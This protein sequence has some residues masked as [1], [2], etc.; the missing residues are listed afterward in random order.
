M[1][2]V[3]V[4]IIIVK[5]NVTLSSEQQLVLGDALAALEGCNAPVVLSHQEARNPEF[6]RYFQL[7]SR[8]LQEKDLL[9]GAK[10]MD[11]TVEPMRQVMNNAIDSVVRQT[12]IVKTDQ[13]FRFV[14][15]AAAQDPSLNL[16]VIDLEEPYA[17]REAHS[18]L[19][20]GL[21][22]MIQPTLTQSEEAL[23]LKEL[24]HESGLLLIGSGAGASVI[25]GAALGPFNQFNSGSVSL[26]ALSSVAL[27]EMVALCD[28]MGVGVRQALCVG[29]LDLTPEHAGVG[30]RNLLSLLASDPE[31]AD[32]MVALPR[33]DASVLS[34]IK[35]CAATVKQRVYVA[36]H[37]AAPSAEEGIILRQNTVDLMMAFSEDHGI[38][39]SALHPRAFPKLELKEKQTQKLGLFASEYNRKEAQTILGADY[40]FSSYAQSLGLRYEL[41]RPKDLFT[42]WL[43]D[44]EEAVNSGATA[45]ILC[46]LILCEGIDTWYI[47]KFFET[48]QQGS[49]SNFIT[50][51]C[52]V[53]ATSCDSM[54]YQTLIKQCRDAGVVVATSNERAASMAKQVWSEARIGEMYAVVD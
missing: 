9:V 47:D 17:I 33:C 4:P 2:G 49:N 42:A 15:E 22:V 28:C 23:K 54:T 51:I 12:S 24:A 31:T 45:S 29:E 43:A 14:R 26:I 13:S 48:I 35:E 36:S 3:L 53:F 11:V 50:I 1:P 40:Q 52:S 8:P 7:L 39:I 27:Q 21:N 16:A 37:G 34:L 19:K 5:E 18:A 20:S 32:I 44:I 30:V 6:Q 38:A 41:D 25:N 46:D 10:V